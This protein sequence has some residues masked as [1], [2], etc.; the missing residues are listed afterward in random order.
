MG[1]FVWEDLCI[2]SIYGLIASVVT[3]ITHQN[4]IGLLLFIIFW[5]VR[6]AGE[7]GY[8]FLQQFIQ[9]KHHPHYIDDHFDLMRK[10]F[11]KISYQ[12]CLI[13]MQVVFQIVLMLALFS[14]IM[15]LLNWNVIG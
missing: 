11:G 14:L 1:A 12:Q 6:S 13:I 5:I 4:R 9:P 8:F 10:I 15:L 3:A 7:A 2:F